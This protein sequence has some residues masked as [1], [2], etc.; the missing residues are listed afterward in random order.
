MPDVASWAFRI[1]R[2]RR[3]SER[4]GGRMHRAGAVPRARR[5][6]VHVR[7]DSRV[8]SRRVHVRERI[9]A[10]ELASASSAEPLIA[11]LDEAVEARNHESGVSTIVEEPHVE[12]SDVQRRETHRG[13]AWW[14][15]VVASEPCFTGKEEDVEVGLVYFGKRF[16]NP[17][18]GRWLSPDP[19]EIHS[20]GTADGNVYAYVEGQ[21][22]KNVD[23]LGLLDTGGTSGNPANAGGAEGTSGTVPG[24]MA[25]GSNAESAPQGWRTVFR[26]W[27]CSSV[28]G[29]HM[30][31]ELLRR[32]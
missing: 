5:A 7:L 11:R 4:R 22:L 32:R 15:G 31:K 30:M 29:C 24:D 16:Y 14:R 6:P 2:E 17:L 13:R 1:E 12:Q 21:A 9:R 10:R 25:S 8:V 18:L 20:A 28:N 27:S 19:L 23:P 3:A 26:N